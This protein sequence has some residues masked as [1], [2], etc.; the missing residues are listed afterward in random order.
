MGCFTSFSVSWP[1]YMQF[2][3]AVIEAGE[4]GCEDMGLVWKLERK[5]AY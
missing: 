5:A 1:T 2:F 3:M 4:T